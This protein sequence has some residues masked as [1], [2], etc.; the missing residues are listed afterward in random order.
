MTGGRLQAAL[1]GGL[2]IGILSSLPMVSSLNVCCCLW[3]VVGGLLTT[4]LRQK[5]LPGPIET[6]EA[7]LSGLIAGLVGAILSI[8][9]T[10]AI[11]TVT[12]PVWQE[13]VRSQIEANPDIPP[14]MRDFILR[15]MSGGGIALMQLFVT[16]P[17][18]AAFSTAGALLGLSFFRKKL[19]PAPPA[20][21]V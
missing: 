16:V 7:V 1:L 14:Q 4:Y 17:I 3:V 11:L 19:P 20:A 15:F 9:G 6:S 2:F 10:W 8:I 12:G 21:I 13:Q 5:Q 18:Y